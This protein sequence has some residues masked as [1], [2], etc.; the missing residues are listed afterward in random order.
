MTN[1][2]NSGHSTKKG[3]PKS[4]KSTK[5]RPGPKSKRSKSYPS[6]KELSM[7]S[8]RKRQYEH[9][10]KGEEDRGISERKSK[11]IAMATVNK[12]RKKKHEVK[13]EE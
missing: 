3:R 13:N 7:S 12:T 6:H 9:I 1:K 11:Q 5:A 8:R 10:L 2:T 4:R